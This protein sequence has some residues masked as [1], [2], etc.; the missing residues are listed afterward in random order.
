MRHPR[1]LL[2]AALAALLTGLLV[3]APVTV[4]AACGVNHTVLAGQNLF[5][6]S[7]RY[8]VSM[9][10]I[11]AA[12]NIA[13]IRRIYTGQVLVIPCATGTTGST[14]GTGTGIT[15]PATTTTTTTTTSTTTVGGANLTAVDCAGFRASS[16]LD[17]FPDGDVTFRWDAPRSAVEQYKVFILNDRGALVRAYDSVGPLLSLTGNTSL[18]SI[19]KGNRFSWYVTALVGGSEVCRSAIAT[20]NRVWIDGAGLSS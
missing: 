5:R 17:G 10:A 19:G 4:G 14:A 1:W 18:T 8:G 9:Q 16:P 2:I 6:I 15:A 7:L 3:M 12:N 20:L 13:D 11:A